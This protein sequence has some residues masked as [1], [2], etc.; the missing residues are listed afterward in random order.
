MEER[1]RNE[2]LPLRE[3]I[4]ELSLADNH[5]ADVGSELFER[6]KDL[7]LR[8]DALLK[9]QVIEDALRR[10][11]EGT[12]GYCESCGAP[13]PRERLEAV[14]YTTL[15]HACKERQEAKG[16]RRLR[17]VEEEVLGI[18]FLEAG[19]DLGYNQEEV[20]EGVA[21]HSLSTELEERGG[22]DEIPV[23]RE[24]GVWYQ[25]FRPYEDPPA[26]EP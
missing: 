8:E 23:T 17:P 3:A 19:D 15:C 9:L 12:Y 26:D 2:R 13:I 5:P 16:V 1:T 22:A 7:A 4:G 14:P 24:D 18:P 21:Q 11:E 10:L 25:D 20:W 6:A